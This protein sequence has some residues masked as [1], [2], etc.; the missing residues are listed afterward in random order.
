MTQKPVNIEAI[1]DEEIANYV[2]RCN[3]KSS[4]PFTIQSKHLSWM[5]KTDPRVAIIRAFYVFS[6]GNE[7]IEES[8]VI[9]QFIDYRS[10]RFPSSQKAALVETK[11]LKA[12]YGAGARV[13][14]VLDYSGDLWEKGV[15]MMENLGPLRPDE[16]FT[17]L[18]LKEKVEEA[19]YQESRVPLGVRQLLDR[20]LSV[21]DTFHTIGNRRNGRVARIVREIPSLPFGEKIRKSY[22]LLVAPYLNGELSNKDGYLS[23]N[24][25]DEFLEDTKLLARFTQGK[26]QAIHRDIN[27]SHFIFAKG[28]KD[29]RDTK[30]LCPTDASCSQEG[31]DDVLYII[32]LGRSGAGP[33]EYDRAG[34]LFSNDLPVAVEDAL[35]IYKDHYQI[36]QKEEGYKITRLI[37]AGILK[38]LSASAYVNKMRVLHRPEFYTLSDR[39]PLYTDLSLYKNR[40]SKFMD[41]LPHYAK[42]AGVDFNDIRD[43]ES[44]LDGVLLDSAIGLSIHKNRKVSS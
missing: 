11:L 29:A 16:V 40:M 32:D 12:Y 4:T 38:V 28:E 3:R 24:D 25:E 18:S 44:A 1:I 8:R 36:T 2:D 15:I 31:Y 43:L 10:K 19:Q 34:L 17:P 33:V 37:C 26:H 6:N 39:H 35:D 9:K 22:R 7:V 23:K 41:I 42:R 30:N 27:A 13:P 14:L 21:L 5:P 20:A